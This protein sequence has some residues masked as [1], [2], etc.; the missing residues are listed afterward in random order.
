MDDNNK[1]V[2]GYTYIKYME[3]YTHISKEN[4]SSIYKTTIKKMV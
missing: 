2:T 3:Q 4:A 1:M